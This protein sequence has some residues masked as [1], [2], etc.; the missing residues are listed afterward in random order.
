MDG[1]ECAEFPFARTSFHYSQVRRQENYE[2]EAQPIEIEASLSHSIL[3][4]KCN[5]TTIIIKGKANTVTVENTSR[6]SLIVDTLVS[7]V[8]VVKSQNF[9]LQVMGSVPTVMMDQVDGA[10]VYFSEESTA[11][12][13]FSSKSS[14]INLNVIAGPD[15]DYKEVPLPS[16]ICSY[17][18]EKRGDLVNEIVAHAG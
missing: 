7:T 12:R 4:S 9:A 15:E 18:D 14:G 6:L 17:Y 16:Q 11:T 3:I 1:C 8:D 13:I 2:K 10:Q 5:N